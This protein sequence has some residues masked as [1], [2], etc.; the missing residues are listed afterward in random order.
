MLYIGLLLFVVV[1]FLLYMWKVAHENNVLHHQ[2]LLQGA[3]EKIRL[4]F[5]S[6]VHLRKVKKK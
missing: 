3:P 4:F 1:A 5:I 2:L 6:D